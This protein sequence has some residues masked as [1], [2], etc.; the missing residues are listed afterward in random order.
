[1]REIQKYLNM[2]CDAFEQEPDA[3]KRAAMREVLRITLAKM[4]SLGGEPA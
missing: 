3:D 4:L 2:L 1:M